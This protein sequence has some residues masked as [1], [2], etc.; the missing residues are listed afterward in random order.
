MEG[1]PGPRNSGLG[2]WEVLE[3]SWDDGSGVRE[4]RSPFQRPTA[5]FL[6]PWPNRERLVKFFIME[7]E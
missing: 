6:E 5:A 2:A 1:R 3:R 7:Q 4:P